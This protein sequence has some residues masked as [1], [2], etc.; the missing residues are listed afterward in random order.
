MDKAELTDARAIWSLL[1]RHGFRFTKSLGQN[2]LTAAWVPERVAEAAELGPDTGVLEVGPG[3]G[4]LTVEL[5]ARAGRILSVELDRSL[6]PLLRETL[7]DCA[8]VELVFADARKL[9]LTALVKE[10]F[11]GL[12]PVVCANLP[13]NVT[14]P[15][16]AAFLEA[17]CFDTITV[18]VQREV[19][20]RL[21]AA[22]GTA[23]YG[24]FSVFTQWHTEPERLFDVPPGCFVP[25][26]KVTSSVIRLRRRGAPPAD[27]PDEGFF[28]RVVRA[29]FAQRRK[30]LVNAL[31]AGLALPKAAVEATVCGVGLDPR[32]RGEELGISAFAALAARLRD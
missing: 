21:C 18:M 20:Q 23:D 11:L 28:F 30:T 8:N 12:R 10:H 19:A 6:E 4:A 3:I 24:A 15:L 9:D 2:F 22:P 1:G 16:L 17:H 31:S 5:S 13:Y 7:A 32:V 27:V 29:A 25:Q 26:P 14:S